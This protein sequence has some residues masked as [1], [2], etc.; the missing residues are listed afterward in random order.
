MVAVDDGLIFLESCSN[1]GVDTVY[2]IGN[3]PIS[4]FSLRPYCNLL[5]TMI[6][7]ITFQSPVP[8]TNHRCIL[9]PFQES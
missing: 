3:K 2:E 4:P 1:G 8:S 7:L 5:I 9:H 6:G